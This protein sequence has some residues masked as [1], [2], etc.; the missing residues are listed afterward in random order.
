MRIDI[1]ALEPQARERMLRRLSV[2][3]RKVIEKSGKS[4]YNSQ[5][6]KRGAIVFDSKR[7]AER[8]DELMIMLRAGEIGNLKLQPTFTLQESY[9]T[10]EGERIRA[11]KYVADFSYVKMVEE[12]D[13]IASQYTPVLVVEDVKSKAT[14]TPQY[15]MK[16]KMMQERFGI[17][18][19]EV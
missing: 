19:Q 2:E 12:H 16:R 6:T 4:K 18:V 10:P 8:Y 17:T 13:D 14:R 7:E 11:I 1:N 15:L 9:M 5:K 3:D